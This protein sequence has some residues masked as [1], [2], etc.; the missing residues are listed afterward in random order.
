[1]NITIE[2]RGEAAQA[3]RDRAGR[4]D[5]QRSQYIADVTAETM[6]RTVELT[7]LQTGT[8]RRGFLDAHQTAHIADA[9]DRTTATAVNHVR[10]AGF[11]EYGTR[12][13]AARAML[14]RAILIVRS[15]IPR[16]WRNAQSHS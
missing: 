14:R 16:L 11:V 10:Y 1:M 4:L 8:L 3:L 5:R 7:P 9:P 15:I 6:A 12:K 2:I 13:M